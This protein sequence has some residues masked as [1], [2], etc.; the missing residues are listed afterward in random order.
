MTPSAET[1]ATPFLAF[2]AEDSVR[3][4]REWGFNCG[5]AALAAVTGKTPEEVRPH[6]GWFERCGYLSSVP[7][8]HA[9]KA[10][11]FM[12]YWTFIDEKPGVFPKHGLM[13]VQFGG[14]WLQEPGKYTKWASKYTHWV[15]A[16]RFHGDDWIFDI[17][18]AWMPRSEWERDVIPRLVEATNRCD[19]TWHPRYRWEIRTS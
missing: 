3:A 17:N 18:G 13:L 12:Y 15:A 2:S 8:R 16:K 5:P 7:M 9:I 11:G 6:L 4:Y 19:G 1:S 10:M 14:P